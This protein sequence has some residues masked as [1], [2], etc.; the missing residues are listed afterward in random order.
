ME[1]KKNVCI[2]KVLKQALG[3]NLPQRKQKEEYTLT[4]TTLHRH[5]F[6]CLSVPLVMVSFIFVML[7]ITSVDTCMLHYFV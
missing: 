4:N 1:E 5:V 6:I 7:Y 2:F 3:L